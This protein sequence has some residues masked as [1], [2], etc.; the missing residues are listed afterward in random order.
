MYIKW[1]KALKLEML[2]FLSAL[3]AQPLMKFNKVVKIR[4]I[5]MTFSIFRE[6][7]L[8]LYGRICTLRLA[9]LFSL[10]NCTI[11]QLSSTFSYKQK[12]WI[13]KAVS[14]IAIHVR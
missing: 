14:L 6:K 5:K 11:S 10:S 3:S 13:I 8:S 1:L 9:A 2:Y 7:R 12:M 4:L